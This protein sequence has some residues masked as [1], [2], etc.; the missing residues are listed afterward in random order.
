MNKFLVVLLFALILCE[1]ELDSIVFKQFRKFVQK[2][3]KKYK[4]INE[5]LAR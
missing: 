3:Y 2:Y 4:S 1:T 5:Y